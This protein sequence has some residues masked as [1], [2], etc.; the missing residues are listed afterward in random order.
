MNQRL[1]ALIAILCMAMVALAVAALPTDTST[2]TANATSSEHRFH[3]FSGTPSAIPGKIEAENYDTGGQ[4]IAWFDRTPGNQGGAYRHDDVDIEK[5][6]TGDVV[7]FV[8]SSEWLIY[9][10]HVPENGMYRAT[11]SASSPWNDREIWVWVDGILEAQVKVKNTGS[12]DSYQDTSADIALPVG[13][14][15]IRL[16]FVRDAQNLD[17][18]SMEKVGD[19][20]TWPFFGTGTSSG[21][22]GSNVTPTTTVTA[23][24][25]T[26]SGEGSSNATV[27]PT[28]TPS[29]GS[30]N[31]TVT[32]T[33]TSGNGSSGQ[34]SGNSDWPLVAYD[35]AYSRNS[36]QTIIGANNVAQL[37][38]I[39][40]FNTGFT[41][42]SPPLIVGDTAYIQNNAEQIDAVDLRTGVSK[43]KYDPNV[44]LPSG[45]LP[46]ATSSHGITYDNGV[47]YAP[48]G[49]N[50]T[51]IAVDAT[52]GQKIWETEPIDVGPAYRISAPPIFWNGI[53]VAGSALGDEPPF[54]V[55]QKGTVTGIDQKT[56][57]KLWQTVLAVGDWVT[58]STNASANTSQNGGGTTWTG[59]AID[60]ETGVVFLPIGNPS[61]DFKPEE[62]PGFNNYT[63][64][65]TAVNITDGSILWSTPFVAQGTVLPNI[66]ALPDGHDWDCSWGTNLVKADLGNG[67]EK[68]VIGHDK[69]GDVMAMNASTGTPIWW[70]TLIDLM[71]AD[72]NPTPEGTDIVMPGPGAGIEAFTATDGKFVY[73]AASN[74]GGRYYSQQPSFLS[75]TTLLTEG[76]FVPDFSL[77]PNGYGN[78][79]I[80]AIDI[81]TG[82]IAWKTKTDNCTFVSPLISNGVVY[83]GQISDF[84]APFEYSDFG[85]PSKTIRRPTGFLMALDSSTGQELWRYN[86]GAQ[87]GIGGPSIGN[88][89]LLVPVGGIQ[90]PNNGG[91]VVAFAV[92]GTIP[93]VIPTA[94]PTTAPT[95]TPTVTQ[96][97]N[98]TGNQTA[99]AATVMIT[100]P[101]AGSFETAGNVTVTAMVSGNFTVVDKQGE[102]NVAGEGH[103]HFYMDLDQVPSTP[104]QPAIPTNTS[105]Q[106]AHVSGTTYTFTNVTPGDHTFAVQLVNNDHTPLIPIETD[107]VTVTVI[108]TGGGSSETGTT[109][110]PTTAA[111][112][113]VATTA[114][115][116]ATTT[117][118][119]GATAVTLTAQG[120]AF[121]KSSITVP[122]GATVTLTFNNMDAGIGHNFALYTD[123]SASTMLF[124]GTIVTGPTTT[125]Y[126]FTAPSTPGTYFYRCD[127]HPTTMNGQFIV[128]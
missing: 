68:I 76:G 25:T 90:E 35:A 69:R 110:V 8:K 98:Q 73:A 32:P 47:I 27:T 6:G 51:I 18:F 119:G 28:M 101:M 58:N 31:A 71:N 23:T 7:A 16:E 115:T 44:T 46:R 124:R 107:N 104:G 128:T 22:G 30:G 118:S 111:T 62:R 40:I 34:G 60:T 97:G 29:E 92:P 50:G 116:T 114:A 55:A 38:P 49:S 19:I 121:D 37:Q 42:E 103:V 48:T 64:S 66:T 10:V 74:T 2:P 79:S 54:G 21:G 14:H 57:A 20:P 81:K 100:S 127:V 26:T 87:V 65:V 94:T 93:S 45:L 113:T 86:V 63:N 85:G 96:T 117:T 82:Q 17:L 67:T 126:T 120:L 59:G 11:F 108:A 43:W 80:S 15:Y 12:F 36:P 41:V 39:W 3:P 105:I 102:A 123:S 125:T 77:F 75:G 9:S 99:G 5:G 13:N 61:P 24:A 89:F 33:P 4:G 70:V 78:G 95:V 112:T 91:Y 53:I 83:S 84:G 122:A 88:G 109:T 56:G 1:I 72:Q 52:T 106:W